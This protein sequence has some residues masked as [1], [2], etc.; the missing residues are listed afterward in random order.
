MQQL[1]KNSPMDIGQLL[2]TP[3]DRPSSTAVSSSKTQRKD[4]AAAP[5]G[6]RGRWHR[7]GEGGGQRPACRERVMPSPPPVSCDATCAH[8]CVGHPGRRVG[9]GAAQTPTGR[10]VWK[11]GPGGQ[12]CLPSGEGARPE[13]LLSL[14][15]L[16]TLLVNR[17]RDKWA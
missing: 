14:L 15:F 7:A 5:A 9:A 12:P 2:Y 16:R 3:T 8:S 11:L 10:R 4:A 17:G 13:G 6:P 1:R